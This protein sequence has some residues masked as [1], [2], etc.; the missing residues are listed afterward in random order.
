[1]TTGI[2]YQCAGHENK[3]FHIFVHRNFFPSPVQLLSTQTAYKLHKE[4]EQFHYD[5]HTTKILEVISLTKSQTKMSDEKMPLDAP[6]WSKMFN[7][8]NMTSHF[9]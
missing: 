8:T 4:T 9:Y 2:L 5:K 1:M 6:I 7:P 3:F